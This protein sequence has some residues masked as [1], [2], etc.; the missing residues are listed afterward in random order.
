VA[1][2]A[3]MEDT[4]YCLVDQGGTVFAEVGADSYADVAARLGVPETECQEY[5]FDLI[6][7]RLVAD[8]TTPG[9]AGS[10]EAFLNE[11]VGTPDKLIR[12]A[13]EGYLPKVVLAELLDSTVRPG[14]LAA[15]AEIERAYTAGCISSQDPCLASG[16]SI[17][18][19]AGEICLQPLARAGAEYHRACAGPWVPLFA[20]ASHRIPAWRH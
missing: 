2:E 4:I 14:Y 7:R 6:N 1:Q 9:G 15:C 18:T 11:R 3:I 8:R 10:V 20:D 17:D 19:D 5:R 16:C 13:Q 12:F